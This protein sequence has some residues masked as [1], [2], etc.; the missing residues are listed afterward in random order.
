MY[1]MISI[2]SFICLMLSNSFLSANPEEQINSLT[3]ES[4]EKIRTTAKRLNGLMKEHQPQ[5][6][7]SF[8]AEQ[9]AEITNLKNEKR[10]KALEYA[11][12]AN[13]E[14]WLKTFDPAKD[15][16][17]LYD[18]NDLG[19]IR[20]HIEDIPNN[21]L[22]PYAIK[23]LWE[24]I[25]AHIDCDYLKTQTLEKK[26][27]TEP[28][29]LKDKADT[30]PD[31]SSPLL[32]DMLLKESE[33]ICR[34]L[35]K[36][37]ERDSY[38]KHH[39]KILDSL[40]P[41]D[42]IADIYTLKISP[43]YSYQTGSKR[44]L[45]FQLTEI[46]DQCEPTGMA[47]EHIKDLFQQAES[48]V[49]KYASSTGQ[50]TLSILEEINQYV[51]A[52][53]HMQRLLHP[54][55]S[56]PP[57]LLNILKHT[58]K[59]NSDGQ[60]QENAPQPISF[61]EPTPAAHFKVVNDT[62]IKALQTNALELKKLQEENDYQ[63]LRIFIAKRW[64]ELAVLRPIKRMLILNAAG[65]SLGKDWVKS[66]DPK[67]N[68][69]VLEHLDPK[70]GSLKEDQKFRIEDIP[71]SMLGLVARQTFWKL[72]NLLIDMTILQNSNG[73][74]LPLSHDACPFFMKGNVNLQCSLE[75]TQDAMERKG[76]YLRR[77]LKEKERQ[78]YF[79]NHPEDL[80]HISA[81]LPKPDVS[82]AIRTLSF[83]PQNIEEAFFS[84]M[85]EKFPKSDVGFDIFDR[86]TECLKTGL[87]KTDVP[88]YGI[89]RKYIKA[90]ATFE[91]KLHPT[92]IVPKRVEQQLTAGST[93]I[94]AEIKSFQKSQNIFSPTPGVFLFNT[95]S[96]PLLASMDGT[97]GNV[98]IE[99]PQINSFPK[100][101]MEPSRT[102]QQERLLK[103]LEKRKEAAKS[104]QQL[105]PQQ[106]AKKEEDKADTAKN[107][108]KE[109]GKKGK[110]GEGGK[111]GK[112][113]KKKTRAKPKPASRLKPA[114]SEQ[115]AKDPTPLV[116][117]EQTSE[118]ETSAPDL[119]PVMTNKD[120]PTPEVPIKAEETAPIITPAVCVK[121]EETAPITAPA[122]PVK[123]EEPAPII[124]PAVR[125]KAEE[126]PPITRP[127]APTKADEK[128]KTSSNEKP[129]TKASE[130]KKSPA[131]EKTTP[132][133]NEGSKKG[134]K[135]YPK[136]TGKPQSTFERKQFRSDPP[137]QPVAHKT[138][139][140]FQEADF[141]HLAP[142]TSQ[143]KEK[144][145]LKAPQQ[146]KIMEQKTDL[147]DKA[148]EVKPTS[149]PPTKVE[150][151]VKVPE[152]KVMIEQKTKFKTTAPEFTP[153]SL[154]QPPKVEMEVKAPKPKH[155]LTI[156]ANLEHVSET[157]QQE[158]SPSLVPL[159]VAAYHP[160]VDYSQGFV[161]YPYYPEGYTPAMIGPDGTMYFGVPQYSVHY[162]P[163]PEAYP[164]PEPSNPETKREVN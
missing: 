55:L 31:D 92:C 132:Q 121:E 20:Y 50:S 10:K 103:L 155:P 107:P 108:K 158:P 90:K 13:Q 157:Y 130:P 72:I 3:E 37:N 49:K 40:F 119:A 1:K 6:V 123:A 14:E 105:A 62:T 60:P 154:P 115:E 19:V 131:P 26:Q 140:L 51:A 117:I 77:R 160:P 36:R 156:V 142:K 85:R 100:V 27:Q 54:D 81:D 44:K 65:H 80:Q 159:P 94:S 98:K 84:P 133:I 67:E 30:L 48:I 45:F 28:P 71:E 39:S 148:P 75:V 151:E 134:E 74:K 35:S 143:Q 128:P 163:Y 16:L 63:G 152:P 102:P 113:E 15:F 147:K 88:E 38:L 109:D 42:Y 126:A 34:R 59:E 17:A 82:Y 66:F 91:K 110:G 32:Y 146:K 95:Q 24:M 104:T 25:H 21:N 125:V 129:P 138:P 69:L 97:S 86:A 116:S 89:A 114:D 153:A 56:A 79:L 150:T 161:S 137:Q 11:G 12:F 139:P 33:T 68:F 120:E 124:T 99:M 164:Y 4:R 83:F 149:P 58:G 64:S 111:K 47:P 93:R 7:R 96:L 57:L 122:V 23:T 141:P 73:E 144:T 52:H 41:K 70:T 135:T 76:T 162:Y 18:L 46:L 87:F 5:E 8:L 2:V 78:D 53:H 112:K 9:W 106:E 61:P 101:S 118:E 43:M 136:W 22:I 29:A 127:A 145:P